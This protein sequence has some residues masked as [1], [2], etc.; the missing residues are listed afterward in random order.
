[1]TELK[2]TDFSKS[3]PHIPKQTNCAVLYKLS[4]CGWCQKM[5]PEWQKLNETIGFIKLYVFTV[6]LTTENQ[7]HWEKIQKSI[8]NK[9]DGF[10]TVIFYKD[11]GHIIMYSGFQTKKQMEN[12]MIDFFK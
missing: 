3:H 1:M 9:I 7:N 2:T 8:K 5:E 11:D 12:L 4:G 10:P 6:D